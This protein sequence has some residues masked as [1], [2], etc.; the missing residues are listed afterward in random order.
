MR[1]EQHTTPASLS[2]QCVH[3]GF[4]YALLKHFREVIAGITQ[5]IT[6]RPFL[7]KSALKYEWSTNSAR[8][9]LPV[10]HIKQPTSSSSANTP[11]INHKRHL[12]TSSTAVTSATLPP[13]G[14]TNKFTNEARTQKDKLSNRYLTRHTLRLRPG[15]IFRHGESTSFEALTHPVTAACSHPRST[16]YD[17]VWIQPGSFQ[18]L[19]PWASYTALARWNAFTSCY[20]LFDQF[21]SIITKTHNGS[22]RTP[23]L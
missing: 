14:P 10:N 18:H 15:S 16:T 22:P 4:F 2:Q 9:Q 1:A 3:A 23:P 17:A 13:L 7:P 8:D 21:S 19:D 11:H 12:D 5:S 20:T 6:R